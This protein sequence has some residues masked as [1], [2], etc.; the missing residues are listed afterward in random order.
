MR[1][2][3]SRWVKNML[4]LKMLFESITLNEKCDTEQKNDSTWNQQKFTAYWIWDNLEEKI[5]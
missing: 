5:Y 4:M 2:N 3:K 1:D